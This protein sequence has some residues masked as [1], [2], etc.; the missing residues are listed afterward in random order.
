MVVEPDHPVFNAFVFKIQ[1]NMDPR[2]RDRIAFL[3]VVSGEFQRDMSARIV[4]MNKS[5]RLSSTH[6]LF[7]RDRETVDRAYAG[8]VI[9]VVGQSDLRIGDTLTSAAT[10]SPF[11]EIPRFSPEVFAYLHCTNTDRVKQFR[12]G[13]EQLSQEGVVQL[14]HRPDSAIRVPL[15]AAVGVLQFEVARARLQSEYGVETRME[16]APWSHLRWIKNPAD[17]PVLREAHLPTG[18]VIALD[19]HQRPALLF[20]SSWSVRYF[21][22]QFEKIEVVDTQSDVVGVS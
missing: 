16:N 4:R 1:A 8:D 6:K 7:G 21:Q 19:Q 10:M 22:Q 3:R 17:L 11:D 18:T 14:L 12:E 20:E 15:L 13:I 5:I 2:H 9:G